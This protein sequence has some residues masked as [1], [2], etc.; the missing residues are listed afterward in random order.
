MDEQDLFFEEPKN[1]IQIVIGPDKYVVSSTLTANTSDKT[2]DKL[3]KRML[4]AE[5]FIRASKDVTPVEYV[6]IVEGEDEAT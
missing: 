3:L 2:F 5:R 1:T 4:Y 6:D